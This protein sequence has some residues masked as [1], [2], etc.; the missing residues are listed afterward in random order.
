M[1]AT[2]VIGSIIF[3]AIQISFFKALPGFVRRPLA[4]WPLLAILIN[5][6]GSFAILFFTGTAYMMG[7]MNMI[8]SVIFGLYIVGYK[9]YRGVH[10]RK[11]GFMKFPTL[12]ETQKGNWLF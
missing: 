11:R 10:V 4:Y 5:F 9:Q 12:V 3:A 7:M 1:I 6:F 2:L 8:S